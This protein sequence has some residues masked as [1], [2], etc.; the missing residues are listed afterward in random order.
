[1]IETIPKKYH[2]ALSFASEQTA[3]V[4][5]VVES[6]KRARVLYF[7]AKENQ[8]RL[9]GQRLPKEL[10][11]VY[12]R[13]S[14]LVALFIS[15]DY[16]RKIWPQLEFRSALTTAL[17]ADREYMLPIRFDDTELEEL[18]EDVLY[19]DAGELEP[20][21]VASLLVTKLRS[22]GLL[23]EGEE[24]AAVDTPGSAWARAIVEGLPQK[25]RTVDD[26]I[27]LTEIPSSN[28]IEVRLLPRH[29]GIP[30]E[31]R[32]WSRADLARTLTKRG[33]CS[34]SRRLLESQLPVEDDYE[35]SDMKIGVTRLVRAVPRRKQP[36]IVEVE[37][38][39]WWIER[40]FNRRLLRAAEGSDEERL[41]HHLAR[42][43][44]TRN[45]DA[46]TYSVQFPSAFYVEVAVVDTQGHILLLAKDSK[47]GSHMAASGRRWTCSIEEGVELAD[48]DQG[49]IDVRRVV[50]RGLQEE[51][52]LGQED[53]VQIR[54]GVV[55][56]ESRHL[57][58]SLLGVVEVREPCA[59]LAQRAAGGVYHDFVDGQALEF[60][61][62]IDLLDDAS[63]QRPEGVW[64]ATARYR[65]RLALQ[66]KNLV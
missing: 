28:D 32:R 42:D 44:L 35:F 7:Y 19:L 3:Y 20:R 13:E 9:W 45:N 58:T 48:V 14:E 57:N 1:M 47:S 21:D 26:A 56:L 6:L 24:T 52:G 17:R 65:L 66:E 25:P 5:A 43:L 59:L 55:A 16:A 34:E 41:A 38:W 23:R 27:C 63:K 62:A 15:K 31:S 10:K 33:W 36:S 53:V 4:D 39:P 22:R 12:Q 50:L 37:T 46:G 61:A 40:E 60:H 2:V 29:D 30:T 8:A 49:K 51:L 18:D 54:F 64:H 11:N